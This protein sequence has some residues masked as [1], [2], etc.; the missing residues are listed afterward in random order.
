MREDNLTKYGELNIVDALRIF[1]SE[2]CKVCEKRN[3]CNPN[4]T[5]AKA[6]SEC[7]LK[8]LYKE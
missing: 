1:V 2:E 8:W 4:L 5:V 6:E 7:F 3:K